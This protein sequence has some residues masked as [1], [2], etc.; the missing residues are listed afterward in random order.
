[1]YSRRTKRCLLEYM[2]NIVISKRAEKGLQ[3]LA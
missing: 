3:E 1:M 2:Q